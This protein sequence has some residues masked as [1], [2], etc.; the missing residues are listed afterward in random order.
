MNQEKNIRIIFDPQIK[1]VTIGAIVAFEC[2]VRPSPEALEAAIVSA[3]A[4]TATKLNAETIKMAVRDMLR[5]GRYKP[6]GRGK[7]A[8]EYLFNA[9][10]ANQFPRINNLVD[11]NNLVSLF[12]LLPISIIDLNRAKTTQFCLRYGKAGESY[13][14]NPAGQTIDLED[15]LLIACLPEDTPCANPIKDAMATKLTDES[16]DVMAVIYAPENHLDRLKEAT[17][18]FAN[19]LRQWG[20]AYEVKFSLPDR[21]DHKISL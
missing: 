20:G 15:L 10:C 17:S 6:T 19:A 18:A 9:A 13:I 2:H 5:H 21:G 12:Y 3:I 14:F 1:N 11:I 16:T 4:K 8:S 7:P